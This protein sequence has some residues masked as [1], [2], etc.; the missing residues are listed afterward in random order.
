VCVH[1]SP[2]LGV[3]LGVGDTEGSGTTVCGGPWADAVVHQ[4]PKGEHPGIPLPKRAYLCT[5]E[6]GL[7]RAYCGAV[8]P[9][10][11]TGGERRPNDSLSTSWTRALPYILQLQPKPRL[12]MTFER[13]PFLTSSTVP[14][15][16][17]R[18][19]DLGRTLRSRRRST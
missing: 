19:S 17:G 15:V 10:V 16:G 5:Q 11:E 1:L 18:P 6:F 14:L 8:R 4:P 12:S 2:L 9:T 3:H 13:W 7:S